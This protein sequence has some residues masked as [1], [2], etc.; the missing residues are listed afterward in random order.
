MSATYDPSL[1][2]PQGGPSGGPTSGSGTRPVADD[3]AALANQAKSDLADLGDEVKSQVGS[4]K[5]EATAQLDQVATKARSLAAEQKDLLTTQIGGVVDAIQKVAAELEGSDTAGASYV[6]MVA[7][8]AKNLSST[9]ADNDVDT[10]LRKAQD[11]GRQQPVAFMGAAALLGFAAS[12]FMLA[13]ASRP[14]AG[15]TPAAGTF[16]GGANGGR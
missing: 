10:I 15:S 11:F 8:N 1:N 13:S 16:D 4:L 9:L 7:D 14:S 6:R 2:G 5:E 3:V 12:R